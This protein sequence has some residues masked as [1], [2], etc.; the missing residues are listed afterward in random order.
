MKMAKKVLFNDNIEFCD[1]EENQTNAQEK[2]KVKLKESSVNPCFIKQS[3]RPNL[4]LLSLN[5]LE[6][7]LKKQEKIINNK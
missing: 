1:K 2:W 6:E 7:L 5:E 3:H 4:Q